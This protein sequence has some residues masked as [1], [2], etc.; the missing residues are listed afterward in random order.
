MQKIEDEQYARRKEELL[1]E[2]SKRDVTKYN[3]LINSMKEKLRAANK[4]LNSAA[5]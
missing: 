2:A 1:Q 3:D 5:E 4:E